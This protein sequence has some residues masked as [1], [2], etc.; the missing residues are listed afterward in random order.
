MSFWKSSQKPL[1]DSDPVPE[2]EQPEFLSSLT[3]FL[4]I[5]V[6]VFAFKSSIL[7]ANNIPS[8]SM[9]PTLKIGDFLFVNKMRYSLRL[10][11]WEKEIYRIDDPQRGDIITFIP[12]EQALNYG[13]SR[14][15]LFARRFVKRVVGMPGD[16]IRISRTYLDTEKGKVFFSKVEVLP[17]NGKEYFDFQPIEVRDSS[18][19]LSDIDNIAASSRT[20]FLETKRNFQHYILE[21]IEDDRRSS[22]GS[23]CDFVRGCKIPPGHYMVMGDNRDDSYDSRGWGFVPREDI[24]GKAM[25]I[26]FSINWKDHTCQYKDGREL[27]ELGPEFAERWSP[28]EMTKHCDDS[29]WDSYSYGTSANL[30]HES[31]LAWLKRTIMY[32]L[33]RLEVRWNRIG[34]ILE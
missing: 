15:G 8:G 14:D 31:R 5:I 34:R 9:I 11:F 19:E 10:P 20:L 3:S 1:K 6:L 12:P 18:E 33:W 24:L 7:D 23:P 29:E 13:E 16:T 21:G 26:Y 28:E 17:E 27:A 30:D 32:R 25:L 4:G 2:E 22:S